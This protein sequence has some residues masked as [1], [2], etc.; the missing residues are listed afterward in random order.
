MQ[1]GDYIYPSA[2]APRC[3]KTDLILTRPGGRGHPNKFIPLRSTSVPLRCTKTEIIH[4]LLRIM[5][6]IDKWGF[7]HTTNP[8]TGEE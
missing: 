8:N 4:N 1:E 5:Y 3:G 2:P 6:Y 7:V